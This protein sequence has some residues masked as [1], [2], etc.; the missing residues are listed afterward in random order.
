MI[1]DRRTIAARE[2]VAGKRAVDDRCVA[3]HVDHASRRAVVPHGYSVQR[4]GAEAL[5][6]VPGTAV[7]GFSAVLQGQA[8]QRKAAAAVDLPEGIGTAAVE[9][10]VVPAV[11]DHRNVVADEVW[12]QIAC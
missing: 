7:A 10:D 6:R 4:Q 2:G 12:S 8:L 11:D 1:A 9:D 3:L 5:D